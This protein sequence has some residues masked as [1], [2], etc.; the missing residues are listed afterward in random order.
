MR[1]RAV[2]RPLACWLSIAFGPPPSQIFSPSLRTW[3]IRSARNRM[4]ASKR[5]E[6]GSIFVVSTFGGQGVHARVS[7]RFDMEEWTDY[8]ITLPR[9][10]ATDG[11]FRAPDSILNR[12]SPTGSSTMASTIDTETALRVD[13]YGRNKE[14]QG[15]A[16]AYNSRQA[17]RASPSGNQS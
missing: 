8:G 12:A 16:L 14:F 1:S 11:T 6:V 5:A 13:L 2:S 17:L 4:L 7:L 15:N 10:R 9:W 3:D